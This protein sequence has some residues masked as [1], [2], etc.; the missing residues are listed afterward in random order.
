MM[1]PKNILP[2]Q[3]AADSLANFLERMTVDDLKHLMALLPAK[4][5]PTRK[6]DIIELLKSF[7]LGDYI[8]ELWQRLNDIQR[9]AVSETLYSYGGRFYSSRFKAKYG[10]LPQFVTENKKRYGY[11]VKPGILRLLMHREGRYDS[12]ALW[13]PADIQSKLAKFVPAPKSTLLDTLETLPETD[14]DYEITRRDTESNALRD[15]HMVLRLVDQGKISVSNKTLLPSKATI[16]KITELLVNDDFYSVDDTDSDGNTIDPFK[17][18]AWPLFIQAAN[19]VEF[20]GSKLS[21]KKSGIKAI[22]GS[23]ADTIKLIWNRWIKTNIIDEFSRINEIKGQ[24]RKSGK[25]LTNPVNRRLA[26]A[27]ALSQC[28][29]GKWVRL[30]DFSNFMQAE[31][32]VFEVTNDPWELY[33]CDQQYGSLGY[34]GFHDWSILQGRYISCLLFE[35]AATLGLIDVAYIHPEHAE[36]DYTQ[37][38]GTDDLLY[39]SRYDG[40]LYFRITDLGAYCFGIAD[41]YNPKEQASDITL[42]VLPNLLIQTSGELQFSQAQLLETY[43]EKVSNNQWRL[44]AAKMVE[45]VEYGYDIA[46]LETFLSEGDDQPLPESVESLIKKVGTQANALKIKGSAILIECA[47]AD[48]AAKIAQNDITGKLC[49]LAGKKHLVLTGTEKAFRSALRKLGYGMPLA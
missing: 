26:I 34:K 39:L 44:N 8:S 46:E 2:G 18:F 9:L 21:L 36:N 31:N 47:D 25:T 32:H 43:A 40:L 35:Y 30:D 28:P 48:T 38:W 13:L 11:G 4:T 41:S 49:M 24:K 27:E 20:K 3:A 23:P 7:L 15:L 17:G 22:A 33:I 37:L 16:K 12:G 1:T 10:E 5:K 6:K 42:S 29:S 45:A 19:L 14:S